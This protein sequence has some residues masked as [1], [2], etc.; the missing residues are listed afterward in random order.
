MRHCLIESRVFHVAFHSLTQD[1]FLHRCSYAG[2]TQLGQGHSQPRCARSISSFPP[3][4]PE[5]RGVPHSHGS[6]AMVL[7]QALVGS[8]LWLLTLLNLSSPHRQTEPC[9]QSFCCPQTQ[10]PLGW[11]RHGYRVLRVGRTSLP[12]WGRHCPVLLP[13]SQG[14]CPVGTTGTVLKAT[15]SPSLPLPKWKPHS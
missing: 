4:F 1:A 14:Q 12:G 10:T 13:S 8:L 6:A 7:Q 5:H 11:H 3:L 9:T 2:V 15:G